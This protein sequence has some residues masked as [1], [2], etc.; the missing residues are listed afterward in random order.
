M[1]VAVVLDPHAT[2][3]PPM[4]ILDIRK[5]PRMPMSW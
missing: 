4:T 3:A 1:V 5:R 2:R